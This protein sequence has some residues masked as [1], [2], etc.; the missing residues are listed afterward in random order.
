MV[1][2]L[3]IIQLFPW[4]NKFIRSFI[5]I[6]IPILRVI[7]KF[8]FT[9]EQASCADY[10][11]YWWN[12]IW[13]CLKGSIIWDFFNRIFTSWNLRLMTHRFFW[14]T[15]TNR[16]F[17]YETLFVI[18]WR[19]NFRSAELNCSILLFGEHNLDCHF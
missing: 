2:R 19:K 14:N 11:C 3:N 5:I 15:K 7:C 8:P 13:A 18:P 6:I 4:W 9:F 12:I 16:F 10:Y 1:V 17:R